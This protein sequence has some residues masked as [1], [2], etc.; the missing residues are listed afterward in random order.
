MQP[1]PISRGDRV[2]ANG[3]PGT[4]AYVRLAPPTYR[5]PAAVSVV[6]DAR[7]DQPGYCGTIFPAG[8]VEPLL[9]AAPAAEA[10][11]G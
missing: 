3:Q 11:E 8:Q 6:L 7:R 4:V 2:E 10:G 5:E 1:Q 9:P